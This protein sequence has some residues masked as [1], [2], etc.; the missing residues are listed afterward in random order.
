MICVGTDSLASNDSL[1]MLEEL[2][3]FA[4]TPLAQSLMWATINGARALGVEREMGSVEVGKR[5]GL[6]LIEG[7]EDVDG[8]RLMPTAAARRLI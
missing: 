4:D 8:L 3:M 7:V 1:S 5:P 6:V 2:K